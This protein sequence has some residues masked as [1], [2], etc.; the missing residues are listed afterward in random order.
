MTPET[1]PRVIYVSYDGMLEPLG[2]SQVLA[3]LTRLAPTHHITLISFEKSTV[4]QQQLRAELSK[5]GINWLPLR[6]HKRP[7]VL[8]TLLDVVAGRRALIR[9]ARA[10]PPDIIHIR[11]YVPALMGLLAGRSVTAKLLFD[12]RGF[13]VDERVEGGIWRRRGVLFRVA[14]RWEKRFFNEADGIVTQT[15]ASLPQIRAW[16]AERRVVLEVVPNC[17]DLQR[18]TVRPARPEGPH[19][20]WIGSIGTWYRFDLA[21]RLAMALGLP[22]TVLT[23]QTD[24]AHNQLGGYPAT[25]AFVPAERLPYELRAGDIGLCLISS[26]FS[27]LASSPTRFAEY[28]AA[29]MPVVVTEGVGDLAPTVQRER[30]GV[31]LRGETD[32]RITDAAA[33]VT[34]LAADPDVRERCRRL[35]EAQFNADAGSAQYAEIYRRLIAQG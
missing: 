19:A 34:Q 13:W 28:L 5:L 15:H 1:R 11:S 30:V 21:P 7:P 31:V 22:L 3:Y 24:L 9:A 12:I 29:G 8:S 14:K 26:S 10:N 33:A 32:E 27:K 35:A 18:F 16:A 2:R 17:V 20:V 23:P 25:V 6:Y 4:K